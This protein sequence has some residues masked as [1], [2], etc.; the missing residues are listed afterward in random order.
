VPL[1]ATVAAISEDWSGKRLTGMASPAFGMFE[2]LG[3]LLLH[4]KRKKNEITGKNE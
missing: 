3:V 2:S 1:A 4:P